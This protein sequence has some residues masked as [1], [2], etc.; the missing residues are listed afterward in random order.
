MSGRTFYDSLMERQA[1]TRNYK[2]KLLLKK[3]E[4]DW[5]TSPQG[6]NGTIVD[7]TTGLEAKTFGLLITELPPGGQSR[8]HKH[9][10]E[11]VGHV[12]EGRGCEIIGDERIEWEAGDT[13]YLPPNIPHR[14]VNLDPDERARILQVEAW[15]LMI[16]LGVSELVQV[17]TAGNAE[18]KTTDEPMQEKAAS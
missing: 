18:S 16:H 11:A 13:F 9:T 2:G 5:H 17:E 1:E 4:I 6:R 7:A 8:L 10:F 12:L 14:H 3:E 15:P